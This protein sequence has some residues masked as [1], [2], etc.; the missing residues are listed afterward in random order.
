MRVGRK[1]LAKVVTLG[2]NPQS[3]SEFEAE[4]LMDPYLQIK[5]QIIVEIHRILSE[6]ILDS[7]NIM[8]GSLLCF[9]LTL[10]THALLLALTACLRGG[11]IQGNLRVSRHCGLLISV[12]EVTIYLICF[13]FISHFCFIFLPWTL[14]IARFASAFRAI[15][16][17]SSDSSYDFVDLFRKKSNPG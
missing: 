11:Q 16:I 15:P 17:I 14:A 4:Y 2:K 1:I 9:A 8:C 6:D 5:L 10:G 12:I 7:L 3:S 13:S